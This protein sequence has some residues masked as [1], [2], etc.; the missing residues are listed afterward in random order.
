MDAETRLLIEKAIR[1]LH[2]AF[3][4]ASR[5]SGAGYLPACDG[6]DCRVCESVGEQLEAVLSALLQSMRSVT[7]QEPTEAIIAAFN[8]GYA[9]GTLKRLDQAWEGSQTKRSLERASPSSLE[10]P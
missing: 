2:I 9:L 10:Q 8:E 3:N 1:K 4:V 6:S 5:H 7:P